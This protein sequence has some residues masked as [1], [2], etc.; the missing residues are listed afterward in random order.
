MTMSKEQLD[1]LKALMKEPLDTK[2]FHKYSKFYTLITGKANQ[3]TCTKCAIRKYAK[4]INNYLKNL[5]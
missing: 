5:N 2:H 3:S 4:L 1:E